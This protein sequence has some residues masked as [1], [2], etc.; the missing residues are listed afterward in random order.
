MVVNNIHDFIK[1]YNEEYSGQNVSELRFSDKELY[2]ELLDFCFE[3]SEDDSL[4][5]MIK[6]IYQ[7]RL[8]SLNT[9]ES[10]AYFYYVSE[11]KP[12]KAKYSGKYKTKIGELYLY[13]IVLPE[14][15]EKALKWFLLDEERQSANTLHYL[16][17]MYYNG[18]AVDC[19]YA[20][21]FNYFSLSSKAKYKESYKWM[22]YCYFYGYGVEQ[23]YNYAY[24]YFLLAIYSLAKNKSDAEY[25]MGLCN[26]HGYG[27]EKDFYKA[28]DLYYMAAISDHS[29][30]IKK[31][32]EHK[33]GINN[34][35]N[36]IEIENGEYTVINEIHSDGEIVVLPNVTH[37][38]FEFA[39]TR[40]AYVEG[41]YH[42][43][44]TTY[45]PAQYDK[46][47]IKILISENIKK[48]LIKNKP[49]ISDE[50]LVSLK[51]VIIEEI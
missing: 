23:N 17:Y 34:S 29:G 3:N 45:N 38:G 44:K 35:I 37:I 36:V 22:G 42:H 7:Y 12:I 25:H 40:E 5:I 1:F 15:N 8:K 28:I 47:P 16:G 43:F 21:A 51:G 39:L 18:L 26:E 31:L 2:G 19:D 14:N 24:K 13:G 32:Q 48:I 6:D 11:C 20:K 50:A 49:I 41:D 4:Y 33:F 30:A 46:K 10:T 27:V 9:D